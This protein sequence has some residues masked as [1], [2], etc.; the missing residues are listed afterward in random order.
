MPE[1]AS[2]VGIYFD[3]E[4]VTRNGGRGMRFDVVRDYACREGGI[5]IRLN[6]YLAY[7]QQRADTDPDYRAS[8]N[9]FQNALRDAGFKVYRKQVRW[10]TDEEGKSIAKANTDLDMAVDMLLQSERLER[11]VLLSGDGDFCEVVRALQNRGCRVEVV[12]FQS[13]SDALR[14]EADFFYSGYLVPGL[15]PIVWNR[16]EERQ[17]G[18]RGSR[19]RGVCYHYNDE[20]GYGFLRFLASVEGNLLKTD[21]RDEQSPYESA[22]FHVSNI[23]GVVGPQ[24]LP[25]R[26]IILE[27]TLEAGREP[28]ELVATD[29]QVA[30]R[31]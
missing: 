12:A 15:L 3:V 13:V 29:F 1:A 7:D 23:E 24:D 26:D 16:A 30:H 21:T 20:K 28:D 4:N 8:S 2:R 14:R 27:F 10:Y 19:V 5:P 25:S 22:F 11:V 18:E 31:Y 17:W 9:N 6:A